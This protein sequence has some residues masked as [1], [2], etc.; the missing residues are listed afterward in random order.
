MESTCS[1]E[2]V[3]DN[4]HVPSC[5]FSSLCHVLIQRNG[6]NGQQRVSGIC[7]SGCACGT[8]LVLVRSQMHPHP[9]IQRT[10]RHWHAM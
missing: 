10:P 3:A 5:V 2:E 9:L 7:A 6:E 8:S 1:G 4:M